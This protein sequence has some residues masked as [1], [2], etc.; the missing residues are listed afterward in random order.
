MDIVW[1]LTYGATGPFP[2]RAGDGLQKLT[3]IVLSHNSIQGMVPSWLL[4]LP[5][6]ETLYLS[7]NKLTGEIENFNSDSLYEIDLS[8]NLLNIELHSFSNLTQIGSL[9]LSHNTVTEQGL[10][11][12]NVSLPNLYELE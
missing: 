5:S 2:S 6:L 1:I 4:T 7:S 9:G 8:N 3:D 10:K 12:V 11:V